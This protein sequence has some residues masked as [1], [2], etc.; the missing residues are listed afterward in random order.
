MIIHDR[1]PGCACCGLVFVSKHGEKCDLCLEQPKKKSKRKSKKG[2][3][4]K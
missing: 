1:W 4:K 2:S 3:K